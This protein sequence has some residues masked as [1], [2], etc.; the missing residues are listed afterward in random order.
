MVSLKLGKTV[1]ERNGNKVYTIAEIGQNHQ[2]RLE[3]AK[4]MILEAKVRGLI[5]P[6]PIKN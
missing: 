2:G 6:F 3:L 4:Q 5:T 1:I